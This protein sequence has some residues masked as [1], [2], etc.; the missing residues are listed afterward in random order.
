MQIF[1]EYV[2]SVKQLGLYTNSKNFVFYTNQLFSSLDFQGKKVLEIGAGKGVFSCYFAVR[3]A[4]RVVSLEPE[5]D[6]SNP[7]MLTNFNKLI[8]VSGT[9]DV[10]ELIPKTFQEFDN[11]GELFDIIILHNSINHLDESACM[12]L[13]HD[14]KANLAY[15]KLFLKLYNLQNPGGIIMLSDC[16]RY[17]FWGQLGIKTPV[18]R[19]IDWKKHQ[20]PRVWLKFLREAGYTRHKIRWNSVNALQNAGKIFQNG[21]AA[22]FINSHF[23]LVASR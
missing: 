8:D 11:Q 19:A 17:N 10:V 1:N 18:T 21:I 2:E 12:E 16:S 23:S 6:G 14:K 9:K 7:A 5:S 3:G 22:Y 13:L 4:S 15:Q 20:Q